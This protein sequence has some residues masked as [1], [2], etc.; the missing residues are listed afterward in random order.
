MITKFAVFNPLE[1]EYTYV[2]TEAEA[3]D[4]FWTRM[5]DMTL[6]HFH[7]VPY[8]LVD[9]DDEG[10]EHWTTFQGEQII[11]PIGLKEFMAQK[12]SDGTQSL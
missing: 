3:L 8:S 1:G 4:L 6:A 5:V 2:E 10:K 11:R 9:V 12:L 7:G